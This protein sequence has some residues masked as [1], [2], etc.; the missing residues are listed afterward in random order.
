MTNKLNPDRNLFR[1]FYRNNRSRFLIALFLLIFEA[2]LQIVSA[3]ITQQLLEAGIQRSMELLRIGLLN[4]ALFFSGGLTISLIRIFIQSAYLRTGL[5]RYKQVSFR[6]LLSRSLREFFSKPNG[7]YLSAFTNDLDPICDN[8]LNGLFSITVNIVQFAGA[9]GLMFFYSVHLTVAVM[10]LSS[11]PLLTG[12]LIGRTLIPAETALSDQNRAFVAQ[13]KDLLSGFSVIKSFQAE[14][15]AEKLFSVENDRVETAR[16]NR[17]VSHGKVKTIAG[18]LGGATQFAIFGYGAYL[19]V[20]G[21]ISVSIVLV[22][23]QLM[24]YVIQPLQELPDHLAQRRAAKELVVRMEKLTE[25]GGTA[26]EQSDI[27]AIRTGIRL[28]NL[29]FAHEDGPQ[30]L[31]GV[32]FDFRKNGAYAIV[33]PSGSGKSTLISLLLGTYRDYDGEIR[34]DD[35]E[36]K[37]IS[38]DALYNLISLIQQEVFIF[39]RTIRENISLFKTF[40]DSELDLAITRSGLD[41][42]IAERGADTK[43]GENG[44]NLSGG[45]RQRISIARALIRKCQVLFVDEATS[46][47]DNETGQKI[48]ETILSLKDVTRIVVTHRLEAAELRK[49]DTILVLKSGKLIESGKFDELIEAKGF[50]YSLFKLN[51]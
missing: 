5:S 10:I 48:I 14:K 37:D 43:C 6:R 41:R 39:D 15:E 29:A 25:A 38:I 35:L 44:K 21:E 7:S 23:V 8:Y 20:Q 13:V 49:F 22:F 3:V 50:F 27:A 45:E 26:V 40:P 32:N 19:A 42:Y 1:S 33:G 16:Y 18:Y 36:L 4:A 2:G 51:R 24:N 46:A 47:L 28:R 30:I 34:Y 17:K 11:V 31:S 12:L 9:I